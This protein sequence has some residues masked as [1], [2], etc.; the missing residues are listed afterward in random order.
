MCSFKEAKSIFSY[1][2][3]IQLDVLLQYKQ[4]QKF[5][6][7]PPVCKNMLIY[8]A[9]SH[10]GINPRSRPSKKTISTNQH[11][12]LNHHLSATASNSD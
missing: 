3:S 2:I 8:K 11:G 12:E 9:N 4:I 1:R 5:K 7:S 10:D 6:S